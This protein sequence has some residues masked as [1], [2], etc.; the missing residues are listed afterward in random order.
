M[1]NGISLEVNGAE[2]GTI[3]SILCPGVFYHD[4]HLRDIL[5][6][7]VGICR[8]ALKVCIII[9]YQPLFRGM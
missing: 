5:L 6:F 1:N 8:F 9:I 3:V 7:N 4:N 2:S